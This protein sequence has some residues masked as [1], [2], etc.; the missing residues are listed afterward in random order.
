MLGET[1]RKL[2]GLFKQFMEKCIVPTI[3]N[4]GTV[5]TDWQSFSGLLTQEPLDYLKLQSFLDVKT[6]GVR[7]FPATNFPKK[8]DKDLKTTGGFLKKKEDIPTTVES[9]LPEPPGTYSFNSN[10]TFGGEKARLNMYP[11]K[12]TTSTGQPS[13][14]DDKLPSQTSSTSADKIL[15]NL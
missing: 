13:L 11:L 14:K 3:R 4:F 15:N 7:M 10:K 2:V 5:M 12:P 8:D 1:E 9:P 6:S